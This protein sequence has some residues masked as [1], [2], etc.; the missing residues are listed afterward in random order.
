MGDITVDK[1]TAV[2]AAVSISVISVG[3]FLILPLFVGAA[4]Q[5]FSLSEQQ[6][7]FFA[8]SVMAG[9]AISAV[10]AI[11]W[12]RRIDWQRAAFAALSLLLVAHSLSLFS[13]TVGQLVF[14]QF[15]ASF[16]G[17]AAYSLALTTLSDNRKP[18]RCFGFAIAA[19][20]LFQVLGL[21]LLPSFS[22]TNGL[23]SILTLLAT[24]AAIGLVILRWLPRSGHATP[25]SPHR[26]TVLKPAVLLIFLGCFM[27]SFN[28]GVV[29]SFIERMAA[30]EGFGATAIGRS[31]AIGV[32]FGV[33]GALLASWS[34]ERFGRM[35]PLALGAATI[36]IA[37]YLLQGG[38]TSTDFLIAIILYNFGWNYSL[39]YQY[40]AVN[41]AD[42][43]GRGVSITPAFHGA[44][45]AI[46][47]S[48][49]AFY[50]TAESYAAVNVVAAIAATLSL[51]LF[52]WALRRS[53]N[54]PDDELPAQA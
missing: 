28:V 54:T 30:L 15:V 10:L 2:A 22:E 44:G 7:G 23:Q 18:D 33:P 26:N 35:G 52:I 21:L 53:M 13:D 51:V 12:I 1:N 17:G 40:A 45:A 11:F 38:M 25:K 9:S 48:I 32:A 36:L 47:P 4:A 16:A 19:Q 6:M 34:G 31:L 8:S 46:G 29:W 14:L 5:K 27:F 39:P 41:A 24:M 42:A 43:S 20:V 37:L 49:A 50:V 3:G